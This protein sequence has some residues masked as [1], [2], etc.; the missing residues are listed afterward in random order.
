MS[1]RLENLFESVTA[2]EWGSNQGTAGGIDT[3]VIRSANFTK[4]HKFNSKEIVVRSI[5]ERKRQRKLLCHGDILI[6]KSGG[7]PDQPVGRVLFY[8]LKG[9]HTCSN[10]ISILRPSR[11]VDPKFLYY[12]LCNLY[13]RGVVKNYQQQT[14]GIINLQLGEYL[15]ESIFFPPLPEQ[16]KIAEILSGI[17]QA[18]ENLRSK[19]T[20][21]SSC[22]NTVFSDFLQGRGRKTRQLQEGEWTTGVVDQLDQI[23]REWEL[24]NIND[25]AELESGHTPSRRSPEYWGGKIPWISL[26]DSKRLVGAHEILE[27]HENT[28]NTGIANSSARLLPRGTVCLSRTASIGKC[29]IMG[30]AM[31]TSQDFANF[32]C[33]PRLNNYYL[34][35]LFRYMQE[36]WKSL[37]GGSTHQTIYMPIFKSLQ[38][39]LPPTAEQ[40]YISDVM[41]SFDRA[42]TSVLAK[43]E[44]FLAIKKSLSGDLLTG[45]KRVS[46]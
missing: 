42:S 44:K 4:D 41:I 37:C 5:E 33:G 25:V 43:I 13:E 45:R 10:F 14:T 6:E 30:R 22:K 38:I 36:T 39:P 34:L 40:E 17:D 9:E 35:F 20:L 46:V 1:E 26:A 18:L 3:G 7:S 2:G 32:I 21:I 15:Q 8:D 27:T 11:Q 16:K 12:S 28:N 23:P 31:A 29:V 24:V 19:A